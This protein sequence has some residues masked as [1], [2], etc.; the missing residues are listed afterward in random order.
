MVRELKERWVPSE[1]SRRNSVLRNIRLHKLEISTRYTHEIERDNLLLRKLKEDPPEIAIVGLGHSDYWVAKNLLAVEK[2]QT[3]DLDSEGR[4]FFNPN[5]QK[6][7]VALAEREGLERTVRL[8]K[9]GSLSERKP[10]Y[11]GTWNPGDP[12]R[13]YFELFIE[14]K[15]GDKIKGKI[16]DLLGLANFEGTLR[17]GRI[18]FV[19]SYYQS[20]NEASKRHITYNGRIVGEGIFGQFE[21]GVKL[22]F[23][24]VESASE[25]PFKMFT[26][27]KK[28][29]GAQ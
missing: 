18:N 9:E 13:G 28:L 17:P 15:K 1:N 7:E 5:P 25:L 19:K 26:Q 6:N 20:V 2:Y 11:V 4:L 23:Y 21:T 27:W 14:E 22:P 8:F 3:F 12:S 16:E 10:D 24:M 29:S